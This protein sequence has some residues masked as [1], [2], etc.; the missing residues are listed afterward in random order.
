MK[1]RIT[2]HIFKFLRTAKSNVDNFSKDKQVWTG[3]RKF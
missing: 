2:A 1:K 3:H